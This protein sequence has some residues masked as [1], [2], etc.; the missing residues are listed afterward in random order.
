VEAREALKR[1]L[2]QVSA[3]LKKFDLLI[4]PAL[5]S[6]PPLTG[7]TPA[8]LVRFTAPWNFNG[9]PAL[10]LAVAQGSIGLPIGLQIVG[11]RWREDLVCKAAAQIERGFALVF[12]P[13]SREHAST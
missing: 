13:S 1:L 7:E 2:H 8:G 10:S 6:F 5:A 11:R 3:A 12:P 4:G 9:W